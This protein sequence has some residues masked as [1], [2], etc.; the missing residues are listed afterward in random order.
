MSSTEGKSFQIYRVKYYRFAIDSVEM[1]KLMAVAESKLTYTLVGGS[2]I[3]KRSDGR[4][5]FAGL[6]EART[7]VKA[8]LSAEI[9]RVEKSLA[10]AKLKLKAYKTI[11]D[12]EL[13]VETY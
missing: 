2:R 3:H 4:V 7:W 11:D 1:T 8:Y 13:K 10:A 5:Y 9:E 12:S 6:E